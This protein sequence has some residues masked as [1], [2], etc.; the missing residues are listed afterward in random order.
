MF[1]DGCV[2]DDLV[3]FFHTEYIYAIP[4][5]DALFLQIKNNLVDPA[6]LTKDMKNSPELTIYYRLCKLKR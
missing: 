1:V 3:T 2:G 5:A 4:F 6:K